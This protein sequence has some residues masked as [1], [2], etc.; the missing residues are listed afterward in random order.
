LSEYFQ[1]K[2]F[3]KAKNSFDQPQLS[4]ITMKLTAISIALLSLSLTSLAMPAED[5]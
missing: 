4:S 3:S 5:V 1:S 2:T